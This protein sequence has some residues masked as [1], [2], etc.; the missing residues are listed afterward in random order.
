M[1]GGR[2]SPQKLTHAG[3]EKTAFFSQK[4]DLFFADLKTAF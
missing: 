3:T 4:N 2:K 1:T